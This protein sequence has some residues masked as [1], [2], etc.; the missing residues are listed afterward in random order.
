MSDLEVVN[1]NDV[2]KKENGQPYQWKIF[3]PSYS[4]SCFNHN[5]VYKGCD[6]LCWSLECHVLEQCFLTCPMW[7]IPS[8]SCHLVMWSSDCWPPAPSAFAKEIQKPKQY[9]CWYFYTQEPWYRIDS[10]RKCISSSQ[11][12]DDHFK[13]WSQKRWTLFLDK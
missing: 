12:M 5:T 7:P 2:F 4:F 11:C 8:L 13:V 6:R 9:Y 1:M 3:V 10:H